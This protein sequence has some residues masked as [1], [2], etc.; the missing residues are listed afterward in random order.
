MKLNVRCEN[1]TNWFGYA[2]MPG[3][4]VPLARKYRMMNENIKV[5]QFHNC[6]PVESLRFSKFYKFFVETISSVRKGL[7]RSDMASSSAFPMSIVRVP[8]R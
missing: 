5:Q 3:R 2:N 6:F 8:A 1:R 7:T 4:L